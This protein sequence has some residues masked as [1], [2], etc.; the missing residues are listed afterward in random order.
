MKLT[1]GFSPCP[2][3]TF[4]F[5]AL[6]NKKIDTGDLDFEV[7][8]ADVQTLNEWALEGK[9]D[10]SK[11]SYGVLPLIYQQYTVLSSGGALGKGVGPLLITADPANITNFASRFNSEADQPTIA[12][13]GENTTAHMLFSL[14]FPNAKKKVLKVFHEIEDAVKTGEVDAGVIIHENRFTY[15]LKGLHKIMD[16][17]EYWEATIKAP[18]PLGGIVARK[19]IDKTLTTRID[20][21]IQESLAY[22]YQHH[23]KEL[24]DYVKAHAQEM[25]E[26]VMRQHINLYVNNFSQQ[27]GTEGEK[28]VMAMLQV[29]QQLHPETAINTS[30]IFNE[31]IPS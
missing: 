19:S 14:A 10:L 23:H 30:N 15:H 16:L 9:L 31:T 29:Y 18:I 13:P 21:L 26:D 11:I 20:K 7:V 24:S 22:S 3:D 1:L 6:V 2:N 12:I 8:L 28:A 5:D 25:S 27:L 17:G 4:I